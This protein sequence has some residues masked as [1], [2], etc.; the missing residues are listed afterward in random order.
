MIKHVSA[1]QLSALS[2]E[3]KNS[4]RKRSHLNTHPGPDAA[5]QRLFIAM[6]PDTYIRPHRHPQAEKWEFFVLINGEI[7]V[8]IF[9]DSGAV[10]DRIELSSTAMRTVELEPNTWH[11][12]VCKKRGSV[13]LEVKEGAYITTAAGDFA[14]WAPAEDADGAE[15]YLAWLNSAQ[16]G[17]S[18]P[19]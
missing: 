9:D 2:D 12:Y 5:V 15:E 7:D 13:A 4:K 16:K 11:S 3:A 6:E 10:S 18:A 8:I 1:K 19:A 14:N 17:E